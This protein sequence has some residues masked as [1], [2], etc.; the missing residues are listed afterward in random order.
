MGRI[1][2]E[3]VDE[4]IKLNSQG[5]DAEYIS[6]LTGVKAASIRKMLNKDP[7]EEKPSKGQVEESDDEEEEEISQ[8][9]A[10]SYKYW[11]EFW[12]GKYLDTHGELVELQAIQPIEETA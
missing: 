11:A 1:R 7:L 9:D 3:V 4:I 5:H 12:K 10:Q 6:D 8:E 2:K